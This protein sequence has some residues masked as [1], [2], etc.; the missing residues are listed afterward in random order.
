MSGHPDP[1]AEVWRPADA[2]PRG[3][4][5][6]VAGAL[7]GSRLFEQPQYRAEAEAYRRFLAPPGPVALEVGFDHGHRLLS[8]AHADPAVRWVGLEVRERRV[9]ALAERAPPNLLAWRADART[10]LRRLTPPGRLNRV[11]VLFPTP[12]WDEGK[13]AKRQLLTPI[14]VADLA[15]ALVPGGVALVA[16]DVAPYFAH[17]QALFAGW[18][19]APLPRPAARPSQRHR[20]CL[21]A[22]VPTFWGAW[23]PPA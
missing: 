13:R 2:T 23:R 1:R 16:T 12:W 9:L 11:D 22:G 20:R 5:D 17:V 19:P 4:E 21:S 15:Q 14:F 3:G 18:Q 10:V 6:D 7:G 8:L